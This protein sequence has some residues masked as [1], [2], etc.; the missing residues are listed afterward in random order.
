MFGEI[1]RQ[2]AT[3]IFPR[4]FVFNYNFQEKAFTRKMEFRAEE[5][6]KTDTT[7]F[8]VALATTWWF[9]RMYPFSPSIM[10]PEPVPSIRYSR[11]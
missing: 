2:I 6:K 4:D 1:A 11:S 8:S 5:L 10:T 7:N 3:W 9:V